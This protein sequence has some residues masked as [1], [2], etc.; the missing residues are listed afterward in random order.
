MRLQSALEICIDL[1]KDNVESLEASDDPAEYV[2]DDLR[3]W[4]TGWEQVA[5]FQVRKLRDVGVRLRA[6]DELIPCN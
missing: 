4:R 2:C 1:V 5:E 6:E 3:Y